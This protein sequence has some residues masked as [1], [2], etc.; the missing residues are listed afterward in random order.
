M[1]TLFTGNYNV[2][3]HLCSSVASQWPSLKSVHTHT[4]LSSNCPSVK[5]FSTY[6]YTHTVPLVHS[7]IQTP[8]GANLRHSYYP[9]PLP[10][11]LYARKHTYA[12][13]CSH[14]RSKPRLRV[15]LRH[16]LLFFSPLSLS[17]FSPSRPQRLKSLSHCCLTT[18]LFHPF[19]SI[20]SFSISLC[21]SPS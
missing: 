18:V 6:F 20:A 4:H 8:H 21:F 9:L 19:F 10:F 3:A 17:S 2:N 7:S 15:H 5:C 11:F 1:H 14:A 13:T 16:I 12:H